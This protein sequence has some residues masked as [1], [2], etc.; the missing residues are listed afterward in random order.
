MAVKIFLSTLATLF[1][2]SAFNAPAYAA[3]PAPNAEIHN[4]VKKR[5]TI[6]GS[7]NIVKED[8]KTVIQFNDDFKTNGGPDLKVFLHPA[9]V[10]DVTDHTTKNG[11]KVGVLKS[12]SGAQSYIIPDN[13]N[14][15]DYKSVLIHCEAFSVLWGGFDIP[16]N[17][18]AE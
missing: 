10:D 6:K 11:V 5:Y 3:D 7:W 16:H 4:F 18:N 15:S 12:N 14:V 13:I 8:G 17:N 1:A 9:S 2:F